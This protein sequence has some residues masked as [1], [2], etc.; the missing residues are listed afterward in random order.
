[1]SW[2]WWL[3]R[4]DEVVAP[5]QRK[6]MVHARAVHPSTVTVLLPELEKAAIP[7]CYCGK[8]PAALQVLV[9]RLDSCFDPYGNLTGGDGT[10]FLRG[11]EVH[12]T[13]VSCAAELGEQ[14]EKAIEQRLDQIDDFEELTCLTCG[15]VINELHDVMESSTLF[16]EKTK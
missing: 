8:R 7:I 16:A 3:R 9:H 2:S 4:R 12:F 6:Q 15:L 5:Q 14:M 11:A 1:M 13:C 10:E